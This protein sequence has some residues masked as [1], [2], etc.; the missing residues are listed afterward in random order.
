MR[1]DPKT[2]ITL[3]VQGRTQKIQKVGAESPILPLSENF[4]FQEIGAH[5]IMGIFMMHS[6]VTLT[7]GK[8]EF[9]S[10]L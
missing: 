9:K 3:W 1:G 10:I 2:T 7:F 4:T 6:K 8:I 5:N